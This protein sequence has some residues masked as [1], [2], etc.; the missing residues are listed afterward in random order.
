MASVSAL[1]S[2][3]EASLS[4]RF[5]REVVGRSRQEEALKAARAAATAISTSSAVAAWTVVISDSSLSGVR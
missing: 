2:T 4:R 1:S 5:P 3:R